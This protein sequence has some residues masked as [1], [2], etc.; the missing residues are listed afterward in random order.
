MTTTI[1]WKSVAAEVPEEGRL[2][3]LAVGQDVH[4]GRLFGVDENTGRTLFVG[5]DKFAIGGVTHWAECPATPNGV[6][7]PMSR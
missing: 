4:F 7:R 1:D 3:L 2:V 6:G 5:A